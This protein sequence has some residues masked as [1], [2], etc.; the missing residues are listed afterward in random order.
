MQKRPRYVGEAAL[1]TKIF[2]GK[3]PDCVWHRLMLDASIPSDAAIEVQSRSHNDPNLLAAQAFQDEPAP[4][5]RRNG[6]EL[7]W[8][9]AGVDTYELLFQRA[10][11]RYIQ[12]RLILSG[13]GRSTPKIRA[14]RAYYPRFSYLSHYVPSVYREDTAS[15]SFLDRFLANTEGFFTSIEDRIA[16]VQALFDVAS[17]PPDTLAW[18]ANWFGVALDPAWTEP[19]QRL[20]LRN[21]MQFFEARGT[22]PGLIMALRLTLENCADQG[23]FTA[24]SNPLTSVR[25]VEGFRNRSLPIGMLQDSAAASGL[26]V[27]LQTNLW[28]PSQGGDELNRRYR[29]ALQLPA[30][31]LYPLSLQTSDPNYSG[32][33]A[34]SRT[35]LGFV[36]SISPDPALWKAFLVTRYFTITAL[37]AA[38]LMN[39]SNF[40]DVALP[41]TTPQQ[42]QALTDWYR[43]Q[44]VVLMQSSAHQFTV[45]LPQPVTGTS[46]AST[47]LA[48]RVIDLEKPAHT[49]YDIQFYWA[50]FRVGD[51]RLGQDSVLD[52]GSRAPQ[53]LGPAVL[54]STYVGSTY[55]SRELPGSAR[56]RAFLQPDSTQQCAKGDRT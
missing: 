38:Y 54:G 37:N 34:F 16:T 19:K 31:A 48:K 32:W 24:Q 2:D 28:T 45:Y 21:A 7:P 39:F 18:L 40:D 44:G 4:Y 25:I 46:D 41:L 10:T 55:L 29:E 50:F 42:P 5:K 1:T 56:S 17:A 22:L 11:G 23:I 43:F 20:F 26:P 12:L 9:N 15:A 30:T 6:T 3:E 35:T 51:A 13:S 49:T 36:P 53:L 14:L 8:T 33:Q 27:Q 47:R 52:S